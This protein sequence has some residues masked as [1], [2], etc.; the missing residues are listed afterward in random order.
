MDSR[1]VIDNIFVNYFL[2]FLTSLASS[3]A[4]ELLTE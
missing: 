4:W 2:T 3:A 1:K